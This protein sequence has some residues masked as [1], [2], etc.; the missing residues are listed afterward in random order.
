M[1]L[2]ALES[3][4]R[5]ILKTPGVSILV[6]LAIALGVGITM[7]MVAL[8]H[9]NGGDPLPE[10]GHTLFRVLLDN[11]YLDG[12]Y[13][14]RDPEFPTDILTA[15]DALAIIDSDIPSSSSVSYNAFQYVGPAEQ[16]SNLRPFYAEI[17]LNTLGFFSMFDLPIQYGA[18]WSEDA[19]STT[20]N[21]AVISSSM[22]QRLFGGGNN[23][24]AD[25]KIAG[26]IYTVS[27]I[28]QPWSLTPRVYDLSQTNAR[29]EAVYIPLSDFRRPQFL[30]ERWRTLEDTVSKQVDSAFL[31]S[32]TIFVQVWVE[33]ATPQA[34]DAYGD[35]MASYVLEQ[36]KLGRLPRPLN[37]ALYSA[38][39]WINVAP[40]NRDT[41][42]LYRVFI[43]VGVFFLLV[44]LLNLLSL[45]LAKFM[46]ATPD[47]CVIR[48][49]GAPRS[50]IFTQYVVE[51][52]ILGIAGGMLS[53]VVANAALEG[54]L[55]VYL[56]NLPAE[57]KQIQSIDTADSSYIKFDTA[58]LLYTLALSIGASLVSALYPAWRSCRIPP[59]E[60]LKMN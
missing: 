14:N 59:A 24:G 60:F 45:L 44:C 11:W 28:L 36:K 27:G 57:Y 49:L 10:T 7:P 39:E 19:D 53:L 29:P 31:N 48:A 1:F 25:F 32:E 56:E 30:P 5:S 16:V 42:Q 47:A 15:R 46:A 43:I 38:Q 17:R 13:Y 4:L 8:H 41:Q 22:N 34:V 51:V 21:V 9:N 35:F 3:A 55:W 52:V 12:V 26:Q 2:L 20:Q 50:L 18:V 37:N 58:L 40:G 54:M 23:V 33:L 6:V